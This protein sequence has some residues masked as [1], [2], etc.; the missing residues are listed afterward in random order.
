MATER[1][2]I[3]VVDDHETSRMTIR[4]LLEREDY[5]IHEAEDGLKALEMVPSL[6]PDVIIL[7]AMM[8]GISGFET[9]S[10]LKADARYESIPVLMCTALVSQKDRN[11]GLQA[12]ADDFL[13]KP[14]NG[15][16]L[17]L[18]VSALAK[19]KAYHDLLANVLPRAIAKRLRQEGGSV[20]DKIPHATVLFT[21]LKGFVSFANSRPAEE[22]VTVLNAVFSSFDRCTESANLEKIKT[23]GDAY[24]LAGGLSVEEDPTDAALRVVDT[25]LKFFRELERINEDLGLS[26]DLRI[27]VHTGPVVGGVIGTK[28]L[29]YDVWGTTVNVA[30]R[31]ESLGVEGHIQISDRTHALVGDRF[32]FAPRGSLEV[33]GVGPVSTWL[34]KG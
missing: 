28:R 3:L 9:C 30:S 21:D 14:V 4:A 31:M 17:R 7:D 8:P 24:M 34:L 25:G 20:A 23:I 11:A 6:L 16:E 27:G 1:P 26:L 32:D 33:K 22:V 29:A 2:T 19:V 5:V 13:S 10:R 15:T 18:R 12:G